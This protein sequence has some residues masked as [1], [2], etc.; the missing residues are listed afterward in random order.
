MTNSKLKRN[1]INDNKCPDAAA[2][3]DLIPSDFI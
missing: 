1:N 3:M 2:R